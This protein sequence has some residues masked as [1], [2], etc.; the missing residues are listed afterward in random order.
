MKLTSEQK[1]KIYSTLEGNEEV[2]DLV[3]LL[4][5]DLVSAGRIT[6]DYEELKE[7]MKQYEDIDLADLKSKAKFVEEQGG[8]ES[9][10]DNVAKAKGYDTDTERI[11]AEKKAAEDN[12][13]LEREKSAGYER[14]L[15]TLRLT[16]LNFK[17]VDENFH[18]ADKFL[19]DVINS[20][21]VYAGDDGQ[22]FVK[23]G[24]VVKPMKDG[25]LDMLKEKYKS[26]VKTP[27]GSGAPL[28]TPDK[29]E[30]GK[31]GS[32]QKLPDLAQKKNAILSALP[33]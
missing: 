8:T 1:K 13:K 10:I 25:G 9:I 3:E 5:E 24:D 21:E 30:N 18:W 17:L 16:N 2:K 33:S 23:I 4:K 15:Q 14:D 26:G 20:G 29:I 12:L 11:K 22:T 27:S 7:S 6:S 19:P 32:N 31:G 28:N